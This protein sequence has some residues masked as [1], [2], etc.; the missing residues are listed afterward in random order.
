MNVTML[1]LVSAR[2]LMLTEITT[3]YLSTQYYYKNSHFL[4][5]TRMQI[6]G[7]PTARTF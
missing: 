3:N 2:P 4:G 1:L 6:K 7:L 5:E